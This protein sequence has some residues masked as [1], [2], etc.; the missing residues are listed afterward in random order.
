MQES[1]QKAHRVPPQSSSS[2]S[3]ENQPLGDA[4]EV[5]LE[6][7][8]EPPAWPAPGGPP[9]EKQ[10]VSASTTHSETQAAA[11]PPADAT[12]PTDEQSAGT[13]QPD[14]KSKP[15]GD[16]LPKSEAV[17]ETLN[18]VKVETGIKAEPQTVDSMAESPEEDLTVAKPKEKVR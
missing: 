13:T 10:P 3:T 4:V 7:P 2:V 16:P 6:N 15:V 8:A 11:A 9:V 12:S 1:P 17:P 18:P 14:I 5:N